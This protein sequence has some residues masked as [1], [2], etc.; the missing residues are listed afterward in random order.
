[1]RFVYLDFFVRLAPVGNGRPFLLTMA[2][3]LPAVQF[4]VSAFYSSFPLRS[5][6]P[7]R[8]SS[9]AHGVSESLYAKPRRF[10][11][12][13]DHGWAYRIRKPVVAGVEFL[14][15]VSVSRAAAY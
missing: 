11:L 2:L 4:P 13:S 14:Q 10:G 12:K 5:P 3:G 1:M 8:L 9:S 6:R 7:L 15:E